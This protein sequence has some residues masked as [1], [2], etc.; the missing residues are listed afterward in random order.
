MYTLCVLLG[1]KDTAE[2][3]ADMSMLARV[4]YMNKHSNQFTPRVQT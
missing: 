1:A 2:N 4:N 3:R